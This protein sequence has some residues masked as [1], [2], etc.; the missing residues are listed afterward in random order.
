MP[1]LSFFPVFFAVIGDFGF[2]DRFVFDCAHHHPVFRARTSLA[3]IAFNAL[4]WGL[5]VY[6]ASLWTGLCGIKSPFL[7]ACL[8]I[9][10]FRSRLWRRLGSMT[11]W[12]VTSSSPQSPQTARCR[13]LISS[14]CHWTLQT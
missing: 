6:E 2:G 10:N 13:T 14:H 1:K 12:W 3:L 11:G 4:E 7:P 5:F 9:I 8:C